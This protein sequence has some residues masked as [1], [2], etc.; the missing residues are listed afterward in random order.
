MRH[1]AHWQLEDYAQRMTT[2]Q[3][4]KLLLNHEDT[5]TFNGRVRQL[6]ARNLGSGVKEVYKVPLAQKGSV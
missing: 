1:P 5:V 2:A 3:W 6:K 4:R